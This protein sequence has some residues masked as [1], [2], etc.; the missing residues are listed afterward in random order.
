MNQ[1][2]KFDISFN[3]LQT[4][5]YFYEYEIDN[6]FFESFEYSEI[7]EGAVNVKLDLLKNENML[8]LTF[9]IKGHVKVTCDRC[10][11]LFDHTIKNKQKYFVKFGTEFNDEIEDTLVIPEKENKINIGHLIYEYIILSLPI[12]RVHSTL[13]ECNIKKTIVKKKSTQETD[14]RWDI[15][16]TL[17]K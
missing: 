4:G 2:R 10:L 13:K 3:G 14:P 8:I 1:L 11:N 12:K 5:S 16:K 15:L 7:Q 17:K 6:R 9:T